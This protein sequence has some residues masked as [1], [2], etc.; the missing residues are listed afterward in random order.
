MALK[1]RHLVACATLA[2][3][4]ANATAQN[5]NPTQCLRLLSGDTACPPADSRCVQDRYGDWFC[6]G[7]GGDAVLNRNGN[8]VCGTGACVKDLNG[9]FQCSTQARG[10]AAIGIDTKAVCSGGCES[11][12]A[13]RCSKLTR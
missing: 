4:A 8:P 2:L 10:A 3:F 11:A 9:E 12:S 1:F 5:Q 13:S 6:S 7:P